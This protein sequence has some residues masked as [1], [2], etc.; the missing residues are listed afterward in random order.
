MK[1]GFWGA[2]L[3]GRGLAKNLIKKGQHVLVYSRDLEKAKE[4]CKVGSTGLATNNFSDLAQV[5]ILFTCVARPIYLREALLKE[6]SLYLK[7]PKGSLHIEC[8][9]IDPKTALELEKY[10]QERG[11]DYLQATLGKTPQM[12]EK[13]LEPIFVGGDSEVQ[14][15][16]WPYLEMIGKPENVG[17]IAASCATKLISNLIGMTN[18]AV[19][20]EG[21]RVGK[22]LGLDLAQLLKILKDTGAHSFQMDVRGPM[23]VQDNFTDPKFRLT[24]AL[25]DLVLGTDM[26]HDFKSQVPL[27]DMARSQFER[28]CSQ[29][30]SQEDAAAIFKL[31]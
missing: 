13:A 2:G 24:L 3:M 7:M 19:L 4:I 23:M 14:K 26:A 15:R 21:L 6:T 17:D 18:I 10:A 29:G 5:E 31:A 9:T 25:K 12:A 22:A 27:M 30:L 20:A 11:I 8:S 16:A 1:I 28:A